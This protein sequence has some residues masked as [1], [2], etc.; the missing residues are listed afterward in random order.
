MS[1]K[2]YIKWIDPE[3]EGEEVETQQ[4]TAARLG[5]DVE[6]LKSYVY[7]YSGEYPTEIAYLMPTRLRLRSVKELG[8]FFEWLANKP[9]LRSAAEI[10][11]GEVVR[12]ERSM[13]AAEKRRKRLQRELDG[14]D[15]EL[16]RLRTLLRKEKENL[17][18]LTFGESDA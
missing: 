3:R 6:T 16:K 8:E 12:L 1:T 7:R 9:K 18:I 17:S 4:Q 14:V 2:T 13:T 11:K 15:Q 5:L 10:S